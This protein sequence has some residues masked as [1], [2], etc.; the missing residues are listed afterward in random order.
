MDVSGLSMA[1]IICPIT[2]W[3]YINCALKFNSVY[4]FLQWSTFSDSEKKQPV[5]ETVA[6]MFG[7]FLMIGF[8]YHLIIIIYAIR[9]Y[10]LAK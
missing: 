4:E 9:A 3:I 1:V 7:F 6:A 10:I 8:L 5:T 2:L